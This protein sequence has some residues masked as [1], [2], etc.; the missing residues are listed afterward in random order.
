MNCIK[1]I[2]VL[3]AMITSPPVVAQTSPIV[4]A[5]AE[6]KSS[7]IVYSTS[8]TDIGTLLDNPETRAV[9]DKHLPGFSTNPQ[10]DMARGVSLKTIQPYAANV[11]TDEVL[12][13]IDA[14]LAKIT[15]K[16]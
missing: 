8:A 11:L 5:N 2:V 12:A 16:P 15:A 10:T 13:K 7:A 14:D 3:A 6:T 1:A 9:L 4:P